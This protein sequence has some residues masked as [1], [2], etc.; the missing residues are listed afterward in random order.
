MTATYKSLINKNEQVKNEREMLQ[1]MAN[2]LKSSERLNKRWV[3]SIKLEMLKR[4]AE[5]KKTLSLLQQ[6]ESELLKYNKKFNDQNTK[7]QQLRDEL[8]QCISMY[9]K[10]YSV[11]KEFGD[12]KSKILKDREIKKVSNTSFSDVEHV[13]M[14]YNDDDVSNN[15][16]HAMDPPDLMNNSVK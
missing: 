15:Y 5:N 13:N 4:E 9:R 14:K 7:L 11:E 8:V 1:L 12:T 16:K 10:I 6:S 2:E 3:D